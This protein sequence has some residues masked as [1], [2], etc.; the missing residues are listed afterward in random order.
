MRVPYR[1]NID[2]RLT[3]CETTISKEFVGAALCGRHLWQSLP[4]AGRHGEAPLRILHFRHS[5]VPSVIPAEAGIQCLKWL[6][7]GAC[8]VLDAE[9]GMTKMEVA[10]PC[11]PERTTH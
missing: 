6:P 4:T 1:M 3:M 10:A 11:E 9:A 5:R 8:P 2:K 7:A